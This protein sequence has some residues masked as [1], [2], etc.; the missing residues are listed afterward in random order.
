[1][2]SSPLVAHAQYEL[3]RAGMYD[4]DADYGPGAIA[5]QVLALVE[6]FAGQEHSGMS[7]AYTLGLLEK[8][9]RF[10]PLTPLTNNPDEWVD[11][12]DIS[13]TPL[14]QNRR[15]S[16]VFSHDGGQTWY[17]LAAPP[18]ASTNP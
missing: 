18:A 17:D 1:M 6:L 7:A 5:T 2:S 15:S 13:D 4:A 14:W 3:D 8:L 9:L 12:S 16:S 11:Q 10:Q